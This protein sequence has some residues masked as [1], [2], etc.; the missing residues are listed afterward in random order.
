MKKSTTRFPTRIKAAWRGQR[1]P[2]PAEASEALGAHW[3]EIPVNG[4]PTKDK[5][6]E[7]IDDWVEVPYKWNPKW[8]PREIN[9]ENAP[10]P[11]QLFAF[12]ENTPGAYDRLIYCPS[13]NNDPTD[14]WGMFGYSRGFIFVNG[15]RYN[16]D[17]TLSDMYFANNLG[18][19][20]TPS[21]RPVRTINHYDFFPRHKLWTQEITERTAP[22]TFAF[23]LNHYDTPQPEYPA[24]PS[25][26]QAAIGATIMGE[27]VPKA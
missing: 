2:T 4:D 20:E 8:G 9:P 16:H 11:E 10:S 1:E 24:L 14:G 23:L 7:K 13:I 19:L 27:G 15:L 25:G 21:G 22:E 18:I 5:W 3:L 6:D 12:L 17:A 26:P